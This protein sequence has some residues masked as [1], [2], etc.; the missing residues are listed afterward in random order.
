VHSAQTRQLAAQTLTA[1]AFQPYGQALFPTPDGA[2]FGPDDA[3]LDLDRGTPRFYIM[4]LHHRGRRFHRITRHQ[5]CTQCLGAIAARPWFLAVAPPSD[6]PEPD[7]QRLQ[8]FRIDGPCFVKLAI[9]TWHAGPYFEAASLDFYNLELS[10]TNLTDHTTYDFRQ[11]RGL[12]FEI[13]DDI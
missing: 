2:P 7:L 12:E 13:A 5:L 6:A 3:Q 10:D 11:A 4:R 9:G 8:A 1:A